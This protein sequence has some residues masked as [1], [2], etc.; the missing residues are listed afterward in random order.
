M[1]NILTAK[2]WNYGR[3]SSDNYGVNS[4]AFQLGARTVYYSYNT[5]ISFCGY[6]SNGEYFDCT[7]ENVWG[8]TTGKHLNWIDGGN[9]K[10]RLDYTEFKKRLAAFLK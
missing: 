1:E 2:K 8:P 4:M 3:Y 9:K 7:C 6:N 10:G 5:V